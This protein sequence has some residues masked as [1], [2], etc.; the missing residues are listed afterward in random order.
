M[1]RP[2]T[3]YVT[4]PPIVSSSRQRCIRPRTPLVSSATAMLT[5]PTFLCWCGA[6]MRIAETR[7]VNRALPSLLSPVPLG[8]AFLAW[9]PQAIGV[10]PGL[11][12]GAL[13]KELDLLIRRAVLPFREFCDP[14]LQVGVYSE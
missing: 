6:E 11:C 14:R 5:L 13:Q 12:Q 8:F 10:L 4:P 3:L 7:A 9:R 2:L 1:S